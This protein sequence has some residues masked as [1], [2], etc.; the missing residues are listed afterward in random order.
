MKVLYDHVIASYDDGIQP[1]G[2][3]HWGEK[4]ESIPIPHIEMKKLHHELHLVING[5]AGADVAPCFKN[6]AV[7]GLLGGIGEE[8]VKGGAGLFSEENAVI[9]AL[10]NCLGDRFSA[11]FHDD[12]HW[13]KWDI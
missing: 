2:N 9:V 4:D 13:I 1:T 12:S 8:I 10:V 11:K 7:V 6:P 3:V 5:P